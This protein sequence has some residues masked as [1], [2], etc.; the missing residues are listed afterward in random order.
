MRS[1]GNE[2]I[3]IRIGPITIR[4]GYHKGKYKG[5]L[6]ASG[7]RP[8]NKVQGNSLD[9]VLQVLESAAGSQKT[10]DLFYQQVVAKHKR[11]R[12]ELGLNETSCSAVDPLKKRR[13]NHCYECKYEVDNIVDLTCDACGWIICGRDGACGCGFVKS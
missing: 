1:R 12:S 6:M 8:F 2:S 10:H 11:R 3:G 7:M 9:E 5:F 4:A 13:A